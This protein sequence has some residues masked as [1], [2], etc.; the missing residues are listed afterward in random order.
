M[1]ALDRFIRLI[2]DQLRNIF[3]RYDFNKNMLFEEDEIEAIL[4]HVFG[5]NETEISHV[6]HKFFNFASRKNKSLTFDELVR[7]LL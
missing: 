4:H 1:S 3:S 2:F 6:L 7:I 5:L